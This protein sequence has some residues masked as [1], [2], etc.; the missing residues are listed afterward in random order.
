LKTA[1][2]FRK[3]SFQLFRWQRDVTQGG[4]EIEHYAYASYAYYAYAL[5]YVLCLG[6]R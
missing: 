5:T 1:E 2:D 4:Y 3:I 6:C